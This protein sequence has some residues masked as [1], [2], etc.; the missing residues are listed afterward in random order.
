MKK[1]SHAKAAVTG[2][3]EISGR[4]GLAGG[5]KSAAKLGLVVCYCRGLLFSL[6]WVNFGPASGL[7]LG[8]AL[9]L[10]RSKG[11]W[12]QQTKIDS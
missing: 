10:K 2:L 11:P 9:G 4:L 7:D 6:F 1:A 3:A 12:A 8:L 5:S